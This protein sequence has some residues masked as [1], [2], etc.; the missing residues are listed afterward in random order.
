MS[1]LDFKIMETQFALPPFEF[2][3]IQLIEGETTYKLKPKDDLTTIELFHLVN[4][5]IQC[6][7]IQDVLVDVRFM[8][9]IIKYNLE[10]HLVQI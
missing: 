8:K 2:G 7:N 5:L 1:D 3:D 10:R 9:Y 4:M 6:T